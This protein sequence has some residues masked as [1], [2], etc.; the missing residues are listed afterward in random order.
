MS[1][2]A[3]PPAAVKHLPP[4]SFGR[5]RRGPLPPVFPPRNIPTTTK[6][7]D[8]LTTQLF[9]AQYRPI[10]HR[11]QRRCSIPSYRRRRSIHTQ[12]NGRDRPTT[13]AVL[14]KGGGTPPYAPTVPICP[15]TS[16]RSSAASVVPL[17]GGGRHRLVRRTCTIAAVVCWFFVCSG[18]YMYMPYDNQPPD[19]IILHWRYRI[20]APSIGIL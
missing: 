7:T 16:S 20:E 19:R 17:A 1:F 9:R 15:S 14:P 8:R 6:A 18:W 12:M 4:P 13:T 5:R 11:L 3:A 10:R 2:S